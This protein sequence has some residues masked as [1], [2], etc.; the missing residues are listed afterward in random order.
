MRIDEAAVRV[1]ERVHRLPLNV[2]IDS[3]G[4]AMQKTES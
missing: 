2:V 1:L 3:C 4:V